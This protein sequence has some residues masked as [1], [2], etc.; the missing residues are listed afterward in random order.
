[1][2]EQ[3][4]EHSVAIATTPLLVLGALLALCTTTTAGPVTAQA[5]AK[6]AGMSSPP[7]DSLLDRAYREELA[8][9]YGKAVDLLKSGVT[10]LEGR[11]GG[12]GLAARLLGALGLT[13]S[14]AV[15]YDGFPRDGAIA[16][17]ERARRLA[18]STGEVSGLA[19]ALTGIGWVHYWTAF[20]DT[21]GSWDLPRRYFEAADSIYRLLGDSVGITQGYFRLGLIHER[22]GRTDSMMA[23][24]RTGEALARRRGYDLELS[25]L[26]RHLGGYFEEV[27]KQYD[28]AL[29]Y[30]RESLA[31][32]ERTNFRPGQ[33]FALIAIGD[34]QRAAGRNQEARASYG[35]A[36]HRAEQIGVRRP[37]AAAREAARF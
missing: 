4:E 27:T 34:L 15:A 3:I 8:G 14:Q 13:L 1:V 9:R 16:M 25:Y 17:L 18:D 10:A 32:R 30:Q 22:K 6:V 7:T 12:A 24:Y 35:E 21:T 23:F 2:E 33:V 37:L 36:L 5:P 26:V 29:V 28:S 31:L 20:D 19:A 11:P